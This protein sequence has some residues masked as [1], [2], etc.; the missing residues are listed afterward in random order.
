MDLVNRIVTFVTAL[1]LI[2]L[3]AVGYAQPAEGD[4]PDCQTVRHEIPRCSP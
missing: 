4:R 2:A 1:L 3:V